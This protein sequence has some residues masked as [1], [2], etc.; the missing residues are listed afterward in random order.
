MTYINNQS[1]LFNEN[2]ITLEDFVQSIAS[3]Q[4]FWG[5][6]LT[7]YDGFSNTVTMYLKDILANGA[8]NAMKD[9][10]EEA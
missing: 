6:D 7:I 4:S 9:L 5:E 2:K 10:S 1:S 8:Y 3:N